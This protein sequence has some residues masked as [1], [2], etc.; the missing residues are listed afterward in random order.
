[1]S[2]PLFG[3]QPNHYCVTHGCQFT[4]ISGLATEAQQALSQAVTE[5]KI[6]MSGALWCDLGEHAFSSRDRKRATF[7]IQTFDE[8]TGEPIEDD[9]TA[10]G[11]HADER[12]TALRPK[13]ELPAPPKGADQELYTEFLEWKAGQRDTAPAE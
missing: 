3:G 10:C 12:R 8:E 5:R 1:M 2:Y 4:H 11:E 13:A 7:K 6:A 9:R